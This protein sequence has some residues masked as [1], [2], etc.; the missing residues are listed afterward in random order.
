MVMIQNPLQKISYPAYSIPREKDTGQQ[1]IEWKT[2]VGPDLVETMKSCLKF[3]PKERATIPQLL[4]Q[5]FLKRLGDEQP[6]GK[7]FLSLPINPPE[8]S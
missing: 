2:K 4:Q 6:P 8:Q 1:I 3:Y 5:P 7:I